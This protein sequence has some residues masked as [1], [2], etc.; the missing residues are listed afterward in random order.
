MEREE[1]TL[2]GSGANA[3]VAGDDEEMQRFVPIEDLVK[4]RHFDRQIIVLCVSWY[5]SFK[6]SLRDLVIM[7][8]ERGISVVEHGIASPSRAATIEATLGASCGRCLNPA[9]KEIS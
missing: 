8:A 6:L 5:T 2:S 3:R 9:A 7:M 4:G 1:N